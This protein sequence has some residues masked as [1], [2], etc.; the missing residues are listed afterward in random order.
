MRL[1][2]VVVMFARF[3]M[4]GGYKLCFAIDQAGFFYL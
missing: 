1:W 2:A 3:K 4:L